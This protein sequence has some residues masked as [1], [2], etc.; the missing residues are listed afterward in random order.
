MADR[1]RIEQWMEDAALGIWCLVVLLMS[2]FLLPIW[3]IGRCIRY[4]ME[5]FDE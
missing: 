5:R 1:D 3:A 2:P 4:V